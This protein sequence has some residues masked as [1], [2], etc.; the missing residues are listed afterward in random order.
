[1]SET[2]ANSLKPKTLQ[3]RLFDV[4]ERFF[5][6]WALRWELQGFDRNYRKAIRE[7]DGPSAKRDLEQ[8]AQFMVQEITGAIDEIRTHRA[9]RQAADE[10]IDCGPLTTEEDWVEGSFG[11]RFLNE[12]ALAAINRSVR[13]AKRAKW[14]FRVK[15]IGGVIGI[16]TGLVGA[17]KV[18]SQYC[19][20]NRPVRA[21]AERTT[22]DKAIRKERTSRYGYHQDASSVPCLYAWVFDSPFNPFPYLCPIHTHA[23][24]RCLP[25]R[26]T[27]HFSQGRITGG[28][29][30][31]R[32]LRAACIFRAAFD[33]SFRANLF[34][35]ALFAQDE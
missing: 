27:P 23:P 14:E 9:L 2:S 24:S 12:K 31:A 29:P 17:A 21:H 7:A 35:L 1:M 13:D 8:E 20:R 28:R 19:G 15:V 32:T 6:L 25:V 16:L 10:F 22:A 5:P 30:P 3:R 4:G 33:V 18:S 26:G 34:I 11:N